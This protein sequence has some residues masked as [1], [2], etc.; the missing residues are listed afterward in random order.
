MSCIRNWLIWS[1]PPAPR[2]RVM[3]GMRMGT[4]M[5]ITTMPMASTAITP[6]MRITGTSIMRMTITGTSITR[7]TIMA[8]TNTDMDMGTRPMRTTITTTTTST[9][10]PPTR[11][12]IKRTI[13]KPTARPRTSPTPAAAR[14]SRSL[15]P[16]P[17]STTTR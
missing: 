3:T 14:R 4:T 8:M 15:R 9:T 7:T 6:I 11:T 17:T 2:K 10:T 16:S 12:I 5:H 13:I 1:A